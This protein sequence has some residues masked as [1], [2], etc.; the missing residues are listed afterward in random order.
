MDE[1]LQKSA[2]TWNSIKVY[3]HSLD[4]SGLIDLIH[5][6][7]ESDADVQQALA[8]KIIRSDQA[9]DRIRR[10][11]VNLVYPDPLGILPIRAGDALKTIRK[12]YMVSGDPSATAALLLDGIEAGTDQAADLGIEDET[13]FNAL[14]QMVRMLVTL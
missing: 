7:Y 11:I 5:R 1:K 9:I 2:G 8:A 14:R 3:L 12:F 6:I 13:Y 10:R 4:K